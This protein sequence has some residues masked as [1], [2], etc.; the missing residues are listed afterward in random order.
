[1]NN[2]SLVGLR[3][4]MKIFSDDPIFRQS[5]MVTLVYVCFSVPVK[6]AFSLFVAILLNMR[7]RFINAYRVIYYLPSILGASV[8]ISILWRFLFNRQGYINLLLATMGAGPIDFLGSPDLAI[9]T[10][11]M[12]SV[13][14]FGSS[15]VLFLAALKQVPQELLEAAKIDGAG[16][17][18]VFRKITFPMIT[19][20]LFFNLIMQ[21]VSAFQQFSAPY[22]I[23]GGG[24]LKSTYLYG[25]MLYDNAFTFLKMGYACAQSWVLFA[26]ILLFTA[27]VFK[28]SPY[29]TY[30]EEGA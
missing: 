29:W 27:A 30:Y 6:L 18:R 11:S 2:H 23:T 3:N 19:P 15:M 20:I 28:S 25:L 14:Q 24:P 26:I 13:W 1:V 10:V 22:L 21:T 17:F 16:R 9:F 8:G 12:L 4:Y 7:I 5:L